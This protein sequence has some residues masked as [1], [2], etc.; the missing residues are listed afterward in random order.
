MISVRITVGFSFLLFSTW[1][2]LGDRIVQLSTEDCADL[3]FNN[4][5]LQCADCES[6]GKAT[7]HDSLVQ[8]CMSCC[9]V[10]VEEKYE[11]AVLEVDTRYAARLPNLAT[12]LKDADSLGVV[13][14]NRIGARP[15]LLMYKER[16]DDLP[17]VELNV[18]AWN[19]D[20]FKEYIADHV[21]S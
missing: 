6:L 4:G 16:T 21:M 3:G 1:C 15:S 17:E 14:R 18:F 13:I 12:V 10:K 11:L 19:K 8:D 7:S 20:M 9:S 2:C 5:V